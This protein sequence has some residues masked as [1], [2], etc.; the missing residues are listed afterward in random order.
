LI[1]HDQEKHV[2]RV[3][4]TLSSSENTSNTV[5]EQMLSVDA[6]RELVGFTL[7]INFSVRA[8]L[9]VLFGPSGAGKSL[10]LQAIAGLCSLDKA[11]ISMG[12]QIWHDSAKNLYVSAQHRKIGY[13]PQSYALFPHL[14][15]AQNIAFGMTIRSNQGRQRVAEFVHLMQLD[16]LERLRPAQLSGGQ[17]QRVALARALAISPRLLLLDE[18]FSALDAPIRETLREEL[19]A[20][21][22]RLHI[23]LVLVTHDALEARTLADTIVVLQNGRVVQA[24]TPEHVFRSPRTNSVARMLGMNTCWQGTITA[25]INYHDTVDASDFV[26]MLRIADFTVQ[27][28]VPRNDQFQ[29]GQNVQIGL[30]TEEIRISPAATAFEQRQHSSHASSF[31]EGIITGDQ[32]RG[33]LHSV[34][35]RLNCG[36]E[37]DI[38]L[39]QREYRELGLAV[40]VNVTLDIPPEAVH[41]FNPSDEYI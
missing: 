10:T 25:R 30:R 37:L 19:R 40:G 7:G 28:I 1:T 3:D 31:V 26:A 8:G 16:G 23:P 5:A 4:Q 36:L 34:T 33:I 22:D 11:R 27:A 20:F 14:S 24:G 29:I 38:P 13:V 18:P 21:H 2:S 15:V 35:V 6:Y 39:M 32:S 12:D 41:L 9:V 17:Q